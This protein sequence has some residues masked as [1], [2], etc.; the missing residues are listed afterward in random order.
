VKFFYHTMSNVL[1]FI[2]TN[3]YYNDRIM[4]DEIRPRIIIIIIIINSSLSLENA[5]LRVPPYRFTSDF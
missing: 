2:F 3:Y 4:Q 1:V 5:D